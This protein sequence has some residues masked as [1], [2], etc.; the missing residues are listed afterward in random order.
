MKQSPSEKSLRR[1]L[2]PSKF[3][4]EGFLGA[5]PR[6]VD[7]IVA[8]DLRTL[9]R[10]GLSL[11]DLLRALRRAYRAAR[12][13]LGAPVEIRPGVVAVFYESRGRIP[14]PFRDGGT[15]EK[16]EAVVTDLGSGRKLVLTEV[17]LALIERHGFFQGRG[18]RY[19]IEP[20]E[21]AE[22]LGLK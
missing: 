8:D 7:E 9:E 11:Q 6:P 4:A 21:A 1:N 15:F 12:D 3:S 16:G 17:G 2:G 10:S 20:A 13:A 18:S 19:R 22:I 14:S 5:D